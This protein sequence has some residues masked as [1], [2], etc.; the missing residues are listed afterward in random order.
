MR[1]HK[2]VNPLLTDI[3]IRPATNADRN[4]VKALVF[5]AL[6]EYGLSPDSQATDADLE[7]IEEN[8]FK[9]GGLFE[10][11]EDAQG[12]LLGTVALYPVDAETCE[13][14]KMYLAP[15]ARGKGLGRYILE[16]KI[17]QARQ[18]GFKHITLETAHVLTDAIRLYVRF[19][20]QEISLQHL[21]ARCDQAYVLHL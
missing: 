8:Y 5:G 20:F 17:D 13:L 10:V 16:R 11:I 15:Q 3:I 2:E 21:S 12:K 14:R 18:R 1:R 19:G 4:E 9:V 7:D 6:A